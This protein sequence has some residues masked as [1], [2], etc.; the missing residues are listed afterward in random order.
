[1]KAKKVVGKKSVLKKQSY[2]DPG[3]NSSKKKKPQKP[4]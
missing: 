1:M 3:E 4:Q 2:G